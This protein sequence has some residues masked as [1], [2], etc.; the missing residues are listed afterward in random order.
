MNNSY[1]LIWFQ[2]FRKAAG[3]SIV[4]TALANQETAFDN[5]QNG[6][7][8][9]Q[10]GKLIPLHTYN[11]QELTSFVDR[12]ERLGTTF[13][14]CEWDIVD[15]D[16]LRKDPRVILITCLRDPLKRFV[17]EFYYSFYRGLH[18]HESFEVHLEDQLKTF[19][20]EY[21]CRILSQKQGV[22]ALEAADLARSKEIL[23][24][25]DFV[26]VLEKETSLNA[27]YTALGWPLEK[28]R[29]TN[30]TGFSRK[31]AFRFFFK[32]KRHLTKRHRTHP[33]VPPDQI[34]S[35]RFEQHNSLDRQLYQWAW[36]IS[37]L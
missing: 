27:L 8:C 7:P 11:G 35:D 32:G 20:N 24:A 22:G 29:H 33:Q 1:R 21:Y 28:A 34:F 10:A 2:H 5:H 25:F 36:Q 4:A 17:S 16:S 23:S 26:C 37:Q 30:K 18:D 31:R 13:V 19:K 14:A 6:N 15:Y 3:S 12:C 9:D